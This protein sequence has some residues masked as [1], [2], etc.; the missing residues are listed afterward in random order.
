MTR[1][2]S[3]AVSAHPHSLTGGGGGADNEKGRGCV[4]VRERE[5][6]TLMDGS[7]AVEREL[8][9]TTQNTDGGWGV[10]DLHPVYCV[11]PLRTSPLQVIQT[12]LHP[13]NEIHRKHI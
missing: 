1:S 7:G 10:R 9:E 6:Q 4:C 3:V 12:L 8:S 13:P 5:R 2:A 11:T